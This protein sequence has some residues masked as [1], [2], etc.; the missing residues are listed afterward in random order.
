MIQK[1]SSLKICTA[2]SVFMLLIVLFSVIFVSGLGIELLCLQK[3]QVAKFS[4]CNPSIPD[5]SCTCTSQTCSCNYCV[6]EISPGVYCQK[7]LSS[8]NNIPDCTFLPVINNTNQTDNSTI[9]TIVNINLV[10]PDDN[11]S[12]KN[13]GVTFKY[14]VTNSTSVSNCSVYSNGILIGTNSSKVQESSMINL[15][16]KTLGVGNYDWFIRCI[17]KNGSSIDSI[18]RSISVTTTSNSTNPT[19]NSINITLL[20]PGNNYLGN[21]TQILFDYN[22][23][24]KTNLTMCNLNVNGDVLISSTISSLENNFSANLSIGNY[25]WNIDCIDKSGKD[26]VSETRILAVLNSSQDTVPTNP[27]VNPG[28]GGG[29]GGG[30]STGG[31]VSGGSINS[32]QT[33]YNCTDWSICKNNTQ[34]RIC[35]YNTTKCK[36]TEAKPIQMQSCIAE[37]HNDES[38]INESIVPQEKNQFSNLLTGASIALNNKPIVIWVSVIVIIICIALI[39]VIKAAGKGKNK[40]NEKKEEDKSDDHSEKEKVIKKENKKDKKD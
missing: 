39:F 37:T 28:T 35:A 3:N 5:R 14:T 18:H 15:I 13:T 10:S 32:C 16:P 12:T 26:W 20:S 6:N 22:V 8:C 36:P 38:A 7:P 25:T 23:S 24:D 29:G 4:L 2:I 31:S 34:S 1:K 19:N 21:V 33:K 30:G 11:Y 27:P 9:N 17:T 40:D